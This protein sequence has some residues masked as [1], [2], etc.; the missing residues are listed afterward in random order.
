MPSSATKDRFTALWLHPVPANSSPK[1]FA[2]KIDALGDMQL[3]LPIAQANL[4]KYELIIPNDRL[5]SHFKAL[6]FPQPRPIVFVKIETKSEEHYAKFLKDSEIV[7]SISGAQEF[8]GASMISADETTRIDNARSA[9][10]DISGTWIAITEAPQLT[11]AQL[12]EKASGI[13]DGIAALPIVQK[14]LVRHKMWLQNDALAMDVQAL[15]MAPAN[16]VV[17]IMQQA[18]LNATIEILNDPKAK[19]Q[20]GEVQ[21]IFPGQQTNRFCVDV[22]VKLDK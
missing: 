11:G 14:N 19:Q 5:D 21:K 9:E 10:H 3:A 6:G 12:A 18:S 22:V 15:G 8:V 4:L 7:K 20:F 13:S 2:A 17:V 16:P 1:D